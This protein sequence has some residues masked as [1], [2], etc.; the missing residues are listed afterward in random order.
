MSV[1]L[2]KI[3]FRIINDYNEILLFMQ[4]G[5][6]IPIWSEFHKYIIFDLKYF[7]AKSILLLESGNILGHV[8]VFPGIDNYLNFGYF[9]VFSHSNDKISMLIDQLIE[10]ARENNFKGVRGPVNIP[11][12]IFGFG[13][14]VEGS[15]TN[16]FIGR[17]VDSPNYLNLFYK[18]GFENVNEIVTWER[19]QMLR[20]NPL[21]SKK[22]NYNNYQFEFPEN[23]DDFNQNYKVPFLKLQAENLPL[24]AAVTPNVAGLIDNYTDF[25]FKYGFNFM[26]FFIRDVSKDKLIACGACI[27]NP[28]RRNEKGKYDSVN[29]YT[30]VVDKQY[31]RK[32]IA[33]LMYGELME[34]LWQNNIVYGSGMISNQNKVNTDLIIKKYGG[35]K[36]RTHVLLDYVIR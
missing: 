14:M 29:A 30:Q 4:I 12:I 10:Y 28:F 2:D 6:R 1:N 35:L 13:F 8:L 33:F 24:S 16:L 3:S 7:K 23:L 36:T 26:I 11:A 18:S 27:P 9:G 25:V 19:D 31:R 20:Y 22:Y 21:K 34:L 15:K 17:S 32:G 5:T